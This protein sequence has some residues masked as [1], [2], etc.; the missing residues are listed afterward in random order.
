MVEHIWITECRAVYDSLLSNL[1]PVEDVVMAG[2]RQVRRVEHHPDELIAGLSNDL[3]RFRG[4]WAVPQE[5]DLHAGSISHRHQ[6]GMDEVRARLPCM[7]S[8][9]QND[10]H[11]IVRTHASSASGSGH[12]MRC[13]ALAQAWVDEGGTASFVLAEDALSYAL[14]VLREGIE[15]L[16]VN[17]PLGST[18]DGLETARLA[19]GRHAPW[20]V[21]DGYAFGEGFQVAAR[22]HGARLMMIDDDAQIGAYACDL[23]VD[24]NADAEPSR[25]ANTSTSPRLLL[26]ARFALLR[27]EFRRS[28][29]LGSQP[30]RRPLR[31]LVT[32][33]GGDHCGLVGKLLKLVE[34]SDVPLDVCVAMGMASELP[35]DPG[36]ARILTEVEDMAALMSKT[37]LAIATAGTT[38]WELAAMGVP[39]LLG[40]VA[41]NQ[42]AV[43]RALARHG[44]AVDIGWFEDEIVGELE[45]LATDRSR[46]GAMRD[47]GIKLVNRGGASAVVGEML[48]G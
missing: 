25:Y 33:G 7:T 34:R 32:L 39:S 27:R 10:R 8:P 18:A 40:R 22:S 48:R 44:A 12:V 26:G 6:L 19:K 28:S 42:D 43:A 30:D 4:E 47:A 31:L 1:C 46:M 24:H 38:A 36:D 5:Q 23:L 41:D 14:P 45:A 37:D 9:S 35:T 13:L 11:L 29:S 16:Q 3:C 20:V 21:G 17:A 2:S 15:V